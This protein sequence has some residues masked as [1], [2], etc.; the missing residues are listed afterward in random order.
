M[1]HNCDDETYLLL[2]LINFM[3]LKKS[4][5]IKS[6]HIIIVMPLSHFHIKQSRNSHTCIKLRQFL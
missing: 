5:T 1:A 4:R 6:I 3:W 2:K